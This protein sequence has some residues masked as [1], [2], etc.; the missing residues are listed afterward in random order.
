MEKFCKIC[1]QQI[2]AERLEVLPD[3]ETCVKHSNVKAKIGFAVY[4]HKTAPTMVMIDPE[5]TEAVRLARRAH[6]RER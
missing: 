4:D 2:P 5:D 6:N 3:T 1:G